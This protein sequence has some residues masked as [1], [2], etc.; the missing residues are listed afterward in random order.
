MRPLRAAAH[1]SAACGDRAGHVDAM[2]HLLR[3]SPGWI[4]FWAD[5]ARTLAEA[6]DDVGVAALIGQVDTLYGDRIERDFILSALYLAVGRHDEAA[7]AGVTYFNASGAWVHALVPL[8]P[9]FIATGRAA[10]I[11][12]LVRQSRTIH[13][14]HVGEIDRLLAAHPITLEDA[15]SL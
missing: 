5:L 9:A 12:A 2:R 14:A 7:A 15:I 13:P 8:I 10:Q 3:L 4:H 1:A 6:G 11:P